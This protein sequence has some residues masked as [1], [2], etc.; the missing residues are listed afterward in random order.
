MRF[1]TIDQGNTRTKFVLFD[2][3]GSILDTGEKDYQGF[4]SRHRLTSENTVCAIANVREE[5]SDEIG[6]KTFN[7]AD[8]F[9]SNCF[10]EMNVNYSNTLGL[11]RLIFAYQCFDGV[12]TKVLI[13]SGTFTTI[14]LVT[15]DGF[16]GGYI[17]PGLE[18]LRQ[19]FF[20][21][22]LLKPFC[23]ESISRR[24]DLLPKDS[25]EAINAGLEHS[26]FDPIHSILSTF[27]FDEIVI[28]GGNGAMVHNYLENKG[29]Q[30]SASILFDSNLV[31][32]GLF[33]FLQK[34]AV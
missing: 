24:I 31:H 21:G 34:V 27:N 28:T 6:L 10:L 26:F 30:R 23:Q 33:K 2:S 22:H 25:S 3:D 1:F 19:A 15:K 4:I 8:Y 17:L 7:V 16:Q 29:F 11:D 13:D 14:D 20:Q 9:S 18:K 32:L 5:L 12:S